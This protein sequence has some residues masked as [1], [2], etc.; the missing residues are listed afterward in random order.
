MSNI[1]PTSLAAGVGS[2]IK[3]VQFQPTAE[4]VPR[5]IVII[6]TKDASKTGLQV[7]APFLS[8]SPAFTGSVAGFGSM[9][10]RLHVANDLGAQG[11][12]TWIQPQA[13]AGGA[14]AAEGELDFTGST[15]VL[16]GTL[17]IY[18]SNLRVP[19]TI[20]DGMDIEAI[21]DATVAKINADENLP[22]TAVK[23]AVTFEVTIT[24]KSK[25]PWGNDISLSFNNLSTDVTPVGITAAVS[26]DMA[27]G[28]GLPDITTALDGLGVGDGANEKFF[29][30]MAHGYGSDST[31]LSAILTYVG[32]TDELSGLYSETVARPFRS[33]IGD[34]STT[35]SAAIAIAAARRI[36]RATGIIAVPDSLSNVHEISAQVIGHA[37]RIAHVRAAEGYGDIV[38][39][40]VDPGDIGNRWTDDYDDRDTAVAAGVGTSLVVSGVVVTKDVITMSRPASTPVTSNAYREYVNIAKIQN[41]LNSVVSN[42]SQPKWQ[43]VIIVDDVAKVTNSIDRQKARDAQAYKND[44][45]SLADSWESHGWIYQAA[46][47]KSNVTVTVRAATDGFDSVIPAIL[48]G[49]GKIFDNRINVDTSIAIL[50]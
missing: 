24:S 21:A 48:S 22:V 23:I 5:K 33:L 2:G 8:S 25:G 6:G 40:G 28:S 27:S 44:I 46:F 35:A 29:T 49:L 12:Q 45:N 18:V 20:T 47:V 13:E 50:L 32:A 4:I 31:T 11:I 15:G 16:A 1:G 43:N 37:E 10:H 39:I 30:A 41:L 9:L 19:V 36:D 42:F 26:T 3:N 34:I 17:A 7:E 38:L 14:A